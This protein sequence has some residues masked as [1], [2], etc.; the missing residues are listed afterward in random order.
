MQRDQV[1]PPAPEAAETG[2]SAEELEQ[3]VAAE[4][5]AREAM[6]IIGPVAGPFTIAQQ[7]DGLIEPSPAD[8]GDPDQNYPEETT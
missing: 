1:Q 2:L 3:E 5:P 7:S 4:L 6:S 8:L